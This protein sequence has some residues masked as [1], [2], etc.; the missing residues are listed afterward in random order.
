MP[1]YIKA[2]LVVLAPAALAIVAIAF[3]AS[4]EILFRRK[5]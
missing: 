1:W 3:F 4:L 2:E 5:Q